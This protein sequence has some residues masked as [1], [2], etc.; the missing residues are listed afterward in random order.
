MAAEKEQNYKNH[1]MLDPWFHI[2][3]FLGAVV[4]LAQAAYLFYHDPKCLTGWIVL[5]QVLF[6]LLMFKTRFYAMKVQDRIIR[7]EERLRLQSL[8]P[9]PL[10]AR[11]PE[12]TIDQ[13]IGLRFA[14][15]GEVAELVEQTLKNSWG[16][17]E[18]KRAV[19]NW[20]ADHWRV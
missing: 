6:I 12:L 20:R 14:G 4:G 7:L 5:S 16:R 8:L 17:E 11:I 19:K 3:I 9:E 1:R 13:L 15:D 2:V 18:I 10:R